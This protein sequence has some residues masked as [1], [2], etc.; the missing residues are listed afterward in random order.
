[1]N[2]C[3]PGLALMERL[4]GTQKQAIGKENMPFNAPTWVLG[5]LQ[6]EGGGGE[7]NQKM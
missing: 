5:E 4:E 3:A 2:G 6:G 7:N 1:M